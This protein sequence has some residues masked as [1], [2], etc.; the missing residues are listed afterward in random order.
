MYKLIHIKNSFIK[1]SCHSF[2]FVKQYTLCHSNSTSYSDVI[3]FRCTS[4]FYFIRFV[5]IADSLKDKNWK[6]PLSNIILL[7]ALV[8]KC[9]LKIDVLKNFANFTG[10]HLCWSLFLIKLQVFKTATLLKGESN[11][12]V[13]RIFTA[14]FT[15]RSQWLLLYCLTLKRLVST[16]R[17]YILK[18]TCSFHLKV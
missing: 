9:S 14:F 3:V 13:C 16:K 11:T 10:K 8:C 7:E 15:E 6:T 5:V 1:G 4:F 2:I 12:S 17:P 18:Q